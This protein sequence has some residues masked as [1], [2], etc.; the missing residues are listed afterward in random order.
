[1]PRGGLARAAWR[2]GPAF[3]VSVGYMDP[4]NWAT[5]IEGGARFGF[6]LLWVLLL[7]NAI[8]LFLQALASKLGIV[9]GKSLA[10]NCRDRL[11]GWL[12][13]L[14]WVAAEAAVLATDLA[15]FLGAALGFSL[16]LGVPLFEAAILTG[17]VVLALL[18]LERYG[19]RVVE[20]AIISLVAVVGV[21]YIV[22]LAMIRP[23]LGPILRGLVEPDLSGGRLFLAIG[24]LGATVMPHNLYLHSALVQARRPLLGE[25]AH[26]ASQHLDA[27]VAL[28]AAL[29]VNAAIMVT[30]A[31]TFHGRGP[32]VTSL[33]QAHA[34]LVP[35]LGGLAAGAFA[36]ALLASGLSSSTTAV[37]A[38]QV[39]LQGF[40]G[41]RV[42]LFVQRLLT[43]VPALVV[44]WIGVDSLKILILSQVFL[45]FGLPFAVVPLVWLSQ[46]RGVMGE[47][48]N[49]RA[50]TVIAS[51]V[52]ALIVLL[53]GLLICR[54]LAGAP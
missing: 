12:N 1:M 11:P 30:A 53:N 40:L 46:H 43:M 28:N 9:T 3:L 51:A 14:L 17:V 22:E 27:A 15:E 34:A 19:Y 32:A 42:S 5:D 49:R 13:L 20:L 44:I 47:F 36:V 29:L 21:A 4:G 31:A 38:S 6:S 45:S 48:A 54:L 23:A 52:A 26:I 2:F 16:L 39:V 50:T 33:A 8:A 25:R 35:L 41:V 10:Q 18:G 7:S 37:M 24:I